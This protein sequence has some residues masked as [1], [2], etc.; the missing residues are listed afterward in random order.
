MCT[1][2][3][4]FILTATRKLF[5]ELNKSNYPQDNPQNS[6]PMHE[7]KRPGF[8]GKRRSQVVMSNCA[9]LEAEAGMDC[10]ALVRV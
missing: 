4:V 5:S 9:A 2:A 10:S 7:V 1:L 6:E 3:S 8:T